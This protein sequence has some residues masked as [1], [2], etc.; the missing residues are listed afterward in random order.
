M[1]RVRNTLC[2]IGWCTVSKILRR[3][4]PAAPT[5]AA[6]IDRMESVFWRVDVFLVSL[7]V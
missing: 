5:M 4:I 6:M 3:I 2:R 7:P 1:K